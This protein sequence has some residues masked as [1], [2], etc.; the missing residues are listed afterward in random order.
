MAESPR[1]PTTGPRPVRVW[2]CGGGGPL[3]KESPHGLRSTYRLT[4][5]TRDRRP[6]SLSDPGRPGPYTAASVGLEGAEPLTIEV[7][8]EAEIVRDLTT[9]GPAA[10]GKTFINGVVVEKTATGDRPVAGALAF[11]WPVLGSHRTD[12]EGRFLVERESG[13]TIIYAYCPDKALAGFTRLLP[14]DADNVKVV[15]SP[16][17]TVTGRVIDSNGKP[18][19]RQRVGVRLASGSARRLEFRRL[20][21]H[22]RRAGPV[23]LQGCSRRDRRGRFVVAHQRAGLFANGPRTVVSF[24][25]RDLDPIQ[26]SDVIVPADKPEK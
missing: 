9:E 7:K 4:R 11:R 5:S 20:R 2:R 22:D 16:T 3:P 23:Y 12:D 13:E 8:D 18:R 6:G 17:G 21:R 24:E 25:V 15:L 1:G 19:A 26:V 10:V 14:A